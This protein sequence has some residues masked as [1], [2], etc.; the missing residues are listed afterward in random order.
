MGASWSDFDFLHVIYSKLAG[1]VILARN[2]TRLVSN[3]MRG[4]NFLLGGTVFKKTLAATIMVILL[5]TK[6]IPCPGC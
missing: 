3:E 1:S 4:G 2:E 6:I 5:E